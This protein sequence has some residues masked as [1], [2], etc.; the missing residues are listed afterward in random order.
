MAQGNFRSPGT[1][2]RIIDSTGATGI[3][4]TGTPACIIGAT[5]KGKAFVPVLLGTSQDFI[6]MFGGANSEYFEAPLGAVEWLRNQQALSFV[7]VLGVGAGERRAITGTNDGRVDGAGFVVGDSQPQY[8]STAYGQIATNSFAYAGDYGRLHFLG[9]VM[10]Q[11]LSSSYFTDIGKSGSGNPI[12]RGVIMAASGV[13]ISL[14]SSAAGNNSV[15][16]SNLSPNGSVVGD[17][18]L[19][20]GTQ[21]FVLLL[22]GHKGFDSY[23]PNIISA[24]FDPDAP[25]YFGKLMNRNP[26]KLEEAGYVLYADFPVHSAIA[27]V[28]GAGAVSSSFVFT[29]KEIA[30]FCITSSVARNSGTTTVPNYDNFEDRYTSAKTPWIT[31][32]RLGGK[33]ENLFRFHSISDGDWANEQIKVSI[34]NITLGTA[35]DPYGNFDVEIRAFDDDDKNK[36]V[37]E[38]FRKVNLNPDSTRYIARVIGD[39]N[40]FFNWDAD[41][42]RQNLI[43]EGDY[44]NRSTYIR[45][46]M[47]SVVTNQEIDSSALPFG[48]RG[49]PHFVTSGSAPMPTLQGAAAGVF[50]SAVGGDSFIKNAVQT[51]VPFRENLI[52]GA[53]PNQ[54]A[55]RAFYWGVQSTRKTSATQPNLSV[56]QDASIKGFVKYYP[57]FMTNNMNFVVY[58]NE[59]VADTTANGVLDADKFNFNGFS[60]SNV[61]ITYEPDG[62]SSPNGPATTL[63]LK[64]WRYVRQGG[65]VANS[66]NKTRELRT[67]DLNN[68]TVRQIAKFT[69]PMFGG[70]NGVRIFNKGENTLTN[71]AVNEELDFSNRGLTRGPAYTAYDRAIDLIADTVENDYQLAAIPGLKNTA[72]TDKA[73][74]TIEDRRDAFYLMDIP[75]FDQN[76]T[77]YRKEEGQYVSIE[78]TI[79]EQQARGLNS[80]YGASFFPDQIVEDT[81]SK[82]VR[83]VSPSV[84]VLGAIAYNDKIGYPWT[85]PAGFTRG[86]LQSTRESTIIL[87]RQNMDDLTTANINPIVAFPGSKGVVVWGQ[88]TLSLEE[89]S[90]NRI[91]VRRLL[92]ELRRRL[93]PI[94]NRI[95]FEPTITATINNFQAEAEPIVRDIKEKR[96]VTDYL[97]KIDTTTTTQQDLENR[98]IRGKIYVQPTEALEEVNIDFEFTASL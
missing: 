1:N 10:S 38:V 80:T 37:L 67:T 43:V 56:V 42:G 9:G 87:N 49:L 5:Q 50:A 75:Y 64:N 78:N 14:S 88:K 97:V 4:P 34:S 84:V 62:I 53:S 8:L 70:F 24:S 86:L 3:E 96:G 72:I 36:R 18:V 33:P 23:Y 57:D 30:A 63:Y 83:I 16:S 46:E 25:N 74:T 79:L 82:T 59:G 45:V 40:V 98:T 21:E 39:Q 27:T 66:T 41:I 2:V 76:G 85:A 48:F 11:S 93:R 22:N 95:V 60:L 94:A 47:G 92:I 55:D 44:P 13:A 81:T 69:V 73:L 91:N 65:I 52:V 12:I 71:Q 17:V 32:Q 6:N 61:E 68:T 90:L 35:V 51:P 77:L 15:A 29:N 54:V 26:Y 19:A 20:N 31:S 58:D 28:T 89:S 7:R